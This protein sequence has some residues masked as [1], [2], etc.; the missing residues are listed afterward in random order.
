MSAQLESLYPNLLC[1]PCHKNTECSPCE[2]PVDSCTSTGTGKLAYFI[3]WWLILFVIIWFII[4]SLQPSW[5]MKNEK[6][7]DNEQH[8]KCQIDQG[9]AILVSVIF[10]FIIVIICYFLFR[11]YLHY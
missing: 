4:Y 9:K 5:I 3:L 8:K 6:S 11:S 1:D 10:A 7:D 2:K